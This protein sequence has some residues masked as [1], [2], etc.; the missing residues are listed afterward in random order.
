MLSLGDALLDLE[1]LGHTITGP[2]WKPWRSLLLAATGERLTKSERVH[3]EQL[4]G[5]A[6]EPLKR[7]D[8]LC[9]V[10]GRRGGK[11]RAMSVL[12]SW[13]ASC[14]D[15][16]NVLAPGER[17]IVLL[18]AVD[19]RQASIML[20]YVAAIFEQSEQ[21]KRLISRR[22][23]DALH[24]KTGISIECRAANFRRLR[25]PTYIAVLADE[26]AFWFDDE[27]SAN[28]AAEIIAAVRPALS[29]THG[30]LIMAS[31]P[32]AR[33]GVLFETWRDNYGPQGDPLVL[34][35]HG[36]SRDLNST[37]PQKTI[38]RALARDPAKAKSEY[39][40][41][42]RTDVESFL[43]REV[44]EAAVIDGRHELAPV[45]G[46][47]YVAFVD[48][49]GGGSDSTCL[50]I[51]HRDRDGIAVLDLVR[52]RQP[53][54]SQE[55]VV[56]EFCDILRARHITKVTGDAYAGSWPA[57]RFAAHGIR[58]ELSERTKSELFGD[59]LPALNSGRVQ[60]LDHHRLVG[61][62]CNLERKV[63]RSGK[64]SIS[65]PPGQHDDLAN[66]CA[67]SLCLVAS[68][69]PAMH[70]SSTMLER[71]G[72]AD[73]RSF[74]RGPSSSDGWNT[75]PCLGGGSRYGNSMAALIRSGRV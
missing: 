17:G 62:L 7:V 75:T 1:V 67:G 11:S 20:D 51:A 13:L 60:L 46:T 27:L 57:E 25:G 44:V 72:P 53:P 39:L 16:S 47:R 21:L 6:R 69:R 32:Y 71:A 24:L 36:S 73:G 14:I 63:A 8:E 43:D 42:W 61:Q 31:S 48:V 49:S 59:L 12:A 65:H 26:L 30:P 5:R 66:V 10:I 55:Q 70:F 33:R 4:T 41:Q 9:L 74:G 15:Y 58:Y 54:C 28:P 37:L 3:F 40:A 2:S 68:T 52:E 19:A 29:T 35:A 38:D 64:D 18:V 23:D 50:A 22:V 45:H 56:E 34:V